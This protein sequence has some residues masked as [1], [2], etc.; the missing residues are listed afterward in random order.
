MAEYYA[1]FNRWW[2]FE[3]GFPLVLVGIEIVKPIGLLETFLSVLNKYLRLGI[4]ETLSPVFGVFLILLGLAVIL[5]GEWLRRNTSTRRKFIA[6]RQQSFQPFTS[7]LTSNDLPDSL[8]DADLS[9]IDCDQSPHLGERPIG[10]V[11]AI[12]LQRRKLSELNVLRNAFPTAEMGY[13]GI[14]H[15]P[16]QFL[17]GCALSTFASVRLFELE[18]NSGKWRELESHGPDLGVE[19]V[20]SSHTK[21]ARAVAI[22]IAI[23]YDVNKAD[24]EKVLACPFED[25]RIG[26]RKPRLDAITAYNQINEVCGRFRQV[27]DDLHHRV[28]D[29]RMVHV[30]YAGPSSL[31]FS[32]GRRISKTIH[33][34]VIVHNYRSAST[35]KYAWGVEVTSDGPCDQMVVV[36]ETASGG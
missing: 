5:V 36:Q 17:A 23:S 20:A 6:F 4:P 2:H 15:V 27:L 21:E 18:R 9:V 11:E 33:C 31:G 10:I 35:P 8:T 34:R 19:A 7:A 13:F 16:L 26:I 30:F 32:L 22:R 3:I 24:V 28:P 29:S 25:I 14:V 12:A 1:K